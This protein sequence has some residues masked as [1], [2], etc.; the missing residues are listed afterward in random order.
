MSDESFDKGSEMRGMGWR[1]SVSILVGVA[2]LVFLLL[3]LIFYAKDYAWEQNVAIFLLSLLLLIGIVGT[4]WAYWAYNKQTAAEKEI[5]KQKGFLWRFSSSIIIGL[6]AIIFLIYWFW[7]LAEPYSIFQNLAIFII[8][9]L[10]A[11][12]LMAAIWVPWGM[13]HPQGRHSQEDEHRKD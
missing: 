2:W 11:G 8:T 4:P 7:F 12:G 5:W 3:W 9:F 6:V 10:I 1:I 13:A